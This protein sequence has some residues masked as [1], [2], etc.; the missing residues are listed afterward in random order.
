MLNILFDASDANWT[1]YEAPLLAAFSAQN[2]PVN[3]TRNHPPADVDYIIFSPA[4][5]ITDFTPYTKTKAV[6]SLWAGVEA[7]TSNP[8]LTQPLAR[9]VSTGL[10]Q[11]MV[12]WVTG[13]TLRY[14]LGMDAHI[15][16]QDGTWTPKPPPLA[17]DRHVTILGLGALGQASAEMLAALDFNVTGWSRSAK[18]IAGI[19]CLSGDTGLTQALQTAEILILLLPDTPA[20]TDL[21]NAKRLSCLP[22]GGTIINPGRGPLIDDTALLNALNNGHIAHA[23]LDVFRIEPLPKN[24]PFWTH[25]QITVTPHIA[26]ETR[27]KSA[28]ESI[29]ININGMENGAPLQHRV[30]RDIGY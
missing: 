24:H 22:K 18:S 5:T 3:L 25:K 16:V 29:A 17:Q 30:D 10:T 4:G 13:H 20:T 26:S 14:H 6:L 21:I 2:I 1:D 11:G 28:A 9:M 15:L 23:T 7:I 8:T 12:E 19:T 27:P